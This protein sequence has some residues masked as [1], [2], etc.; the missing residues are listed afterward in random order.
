MNVQEGDRGSIHVCFVY[1]FERER[2]NVCVSYLQEIC[3]FLSAENCET[4]HFSPR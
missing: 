3:I 1:L 4:S 2:V